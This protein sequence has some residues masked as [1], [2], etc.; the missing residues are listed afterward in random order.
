MLGNMFAEYTIL[1]SLKLRTTF[2]ADYNGSQRDFFRSSRI[3]S[4]SLSEP[5]SGDAASNRALN[6]LNENTLTYAYKDKQH[7]VDAVGGFTVQRSYQRSI[8][9]N[10]RN[11]PD[12]LIQ[13]ISGGQIT[14]GSY[15]INE[16]SLVSVLG[17]VNYSYLDRYLLTATI[18]SDGSSRFGPSSRWGSFPSASFGYRI[19]KERFMKKIQFIDDLKL[20]L[21][22]GLSGN[23]AIG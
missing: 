13:N 12:D 23:N 16:W 20:R 6:W 8:V 11:F 4:A 15:T 22:Y 7:R 9:A 10:G 17:R 14:S 21:S 3:S 1:K 5:A 19:S 18:R 2:G